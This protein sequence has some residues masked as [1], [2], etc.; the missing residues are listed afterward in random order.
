[1]TVLTAPVEWAAWRR[2]GLKRG[3][4]SEHASEAALRRPV[5]QTD[6][7]STPNNSSQLIR[8]RLVIGRKHDPAGRRDNVEAR[9]I[10]A[11]ETL[12]VSDPVIDLESLLP[13][14]FFRC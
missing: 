3:H 5:G 10:N 13:C 9:V 12:A 4:H 14:S 2:A 8:S 1:H 7:S 6:A 11:V